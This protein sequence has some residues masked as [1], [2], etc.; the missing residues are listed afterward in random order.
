V[1]EL[2]VEEESS[3]TVEALPGVQAQEVMKIPEADLKEVV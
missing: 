3:V 1:E 2:G